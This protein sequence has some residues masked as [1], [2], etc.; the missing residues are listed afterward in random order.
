MSKF[1]SFPSIDAFRHVIRNV[2]H[3][4]AFEGLDENGEPIY[5]SLKPKPTIKFTGTVKLHGTNAGVSYDGEKIWAQSRNNVITPEKDNAGFAFFV[6]SNKELFLNLMKEVKEKHKVADGNIIT[7]YGEWCGGNIQKGVAICELNKMFVIFKIKVATPDEEVANFWLD[8][9]YKDFTDMST[10]A[11]ISFI[12]SYPTFEMDID[13][14]NPE[15]SQNKL[16]EITTQVEAE[17][18]VGKAHGVS[19]IGE[20]VVWTGIHGENNYVFKVKGE[21]HSVSKVKKLASVDVEKLANI[22]EFVD[23]SVTEGRLE[24]GVEVIFTSQNKEIEKK[25]MGD[26]LRW[27]RNDII[28]EELD[29]LIKNG[30]EPKEVGGPISKK[31]ATWFSVKYF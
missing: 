26:F 21:K 5:N 15:L 23:Y 8:Y 17:C 10:K 7:V 6:E 2:S 22:K 1:I 13:F 24:Q 27:V 14:N 31:A 30:L 4:A 20:G 9:N 12:Q 28:K 25:G 18:P 16:I 3:H 19:G 11:R 29:T